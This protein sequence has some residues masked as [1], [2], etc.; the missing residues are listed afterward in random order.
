MSF[1]I[2]DFLRHFPS[3]ESI[4]MKFSVPGHSCV[5]EVDNMHSQI[6][7]HMRPFEF[8]SQLLLRRIFK[9]AHRR[10]PYVIIQM[11]ESEFNDYQSCAS[12]FQYNN[13]PFSKVSVL[14]FTTE[15]SVMFKV[16]HLDNNFTCTD[17][18]ASIQTRQKRAPPSTRT[19][20][21]ELPKPM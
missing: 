4:I 15:P 21:Y 5:Q 16:S 18:R 12:L 1:A 14:K 19:P 2:F 7:N 17:I 6:E 8:F 10:K 20:L 9:G 13:V 11:K 3:V